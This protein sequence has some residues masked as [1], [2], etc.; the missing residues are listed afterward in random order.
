M[1][2]DTIDGDPWLYIT[3]RLRHILHK[4]AQ[5][6]HSGR[7]SDAKTAVYTFKIIQGY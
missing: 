6:C 1:L 2:I 4:E 3:Y 5:I 7:Y